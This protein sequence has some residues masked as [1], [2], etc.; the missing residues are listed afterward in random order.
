MRTSRMI[1][2]LM[3]LF[4][5]LLGGCAAMSQ[6]G[7]TLSLKATPQTVH[8]GFFDATIPPV[9]TINSGDT[10]SLSTMMLMDGQLRCGMTM[11]ELFAKRQSYVDRKVGPHT[12]TGPIFVKGAEPGDVL[13]IRIQK[14]VPASCGVN[15]L[16]PGE[17]ESRGI[18]RRFS[19]RSIQDPA[20][21]LAEDG[22]HL[23]SWN[24]NSAQAFS[25]SD[26]GGAQ[27][28]RKA[29]GCGSGL[30]RREHGQ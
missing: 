29:T 15:Y 19:H 23:C 9:L 10:V 11:E 24:C 17:D 25:G 22:N 14:L 12:L 28:W 26:G 2:L 7:K 13:E 6:G 27:T 5:F 1:G 16:M 4:L 8:T 20:A 30:F 21:R 3:L 18:T